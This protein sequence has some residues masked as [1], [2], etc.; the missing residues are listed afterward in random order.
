AEMFGGAYRTLLVAQAHYIDAKISFLR[1]RTG[2]V[3]LHMA[4]YFSLQMAARLRLR[5][6]GEAVRA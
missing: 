5:F 1:R 6:T 4:A 2:D 3:A